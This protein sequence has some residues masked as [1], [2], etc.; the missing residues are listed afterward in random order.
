MLQ[1]QKKKSLS[2]S[3]RAEV[4][5]ICQWGRWPVMSHGEMEQLKN[6]GVP[7]ETHEILV[8]FI[9]ILRMA[10]YNPRITG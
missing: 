8:V 10:C 1:P 4:D 5:F 7:Y 9:L 2:G 6:P 3:F